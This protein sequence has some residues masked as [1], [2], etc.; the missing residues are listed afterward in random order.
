MSSHDQEDDLH[1]WYPGFW[2]LPA[3]RRGTAQAS[4]SLSTWTV[5]GRWVSGRSAPSRCPRFHQHLVLVSAYHHVPQAFV[6]NSFDARFLFL[7]LLYIPLS[8]FLE[9]YARHVAIPMAHVEE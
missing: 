2:N 8:V 6:I 9:Y 5:G 3:L 1:Q 7:N 4:P